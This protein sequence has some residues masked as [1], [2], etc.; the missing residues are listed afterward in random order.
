MRQYESRSTNSCPYKFLTNVA[1]SSKHNDT[2]QP[3]KAAGSI[4]TYKCYRIDEIK[5]RAWLTFL[6]LASAQYSCEPKTDKP[7]GLGKFVYT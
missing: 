2:I 6:R 7:T 1:H 5:K 3:T 4:T